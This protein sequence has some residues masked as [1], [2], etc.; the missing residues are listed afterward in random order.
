MFYRTA[1]PMERIVTS[2]ASICHISVLFSHIGIRQK[3]RADLSLRFTIHDTAVC[4]VSRKDKH[5]GNLY[6]C[7]G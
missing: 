4:L 7:R 5:L 2:V 3:L 1:L 6:M